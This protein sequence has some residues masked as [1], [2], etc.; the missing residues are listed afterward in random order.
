MRTRGRLLRMMVVVVLAGAPGYVGGSEP[1][2][3]NSAGARGER[4]ARGVDVESAG[5]GAV[6]RRY[7]FL[8]GV[9]DYGW[10]DRAGDG[11]RLDNLSFCV[12]DMESLKKKLDAIGFVRVYCMTTESTLSW[13]PTKDRIQRRF[14]QLLDDDKMDADDL[15]LVALAGHGLARPAADGNTASYFCPADAHSERTETMIAVDWFY[16]RLA[17][18]KAG[19]KLLVVDACRNLVKPRAAGDAPKLSPEARG[20]MKSLADSM[21]PRGIAALLSCSSGEFSHEVPDLGHGVFM[22]FV[23]EGL[24]KADRAAGNRDG[25]V[26][27]SGPVHVTAAQTQQYVDTACPGTYSKPRPLLRR[28]LPNYKLVRVARPPG[29][30]MPREL[31]LPFTVREKDRNGKLLEGATVQLL[32]RQSSGAPEAA[33]GRAQSDSRGRAEI[34]IP[35]HW[36]LVQGDFGVVVADRGASRRYALTDF[37]GPRSWSLYVPKDEPSSPSPVVPGQEPK[38]I[39]NSSGMKLPWIPAGA[40]LMGSPQ[41]EEHREDNEYQHRVRITK[42]FYLGADEVTQAEYERVMGKNPSWFSANGDGSEQ[43]QGMDTSRFPVEQVSWAEA[44]EFCRK[45]SSLPEGQRAGRVYRLPTEAEWEY[46]CRAGTRS[47]F[48]FGDSL[49]S[50]QANFDGDSPY[51][52]ASEGPDLGRPRPVGSYKPNGWGLYDMHGNVY[53]WCRDWYDAEYY[54]NSPV[55]DPV[56]PSSEAFSRVCRGGC[57]SFDAGYCRSSNRDGVSPSYRDNPLGFRVAAGPSGR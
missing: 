38:T 53:E 34:T 55:D 3:G 6:S 28:D 37:P 16:K 25:E 18:S 35:G 8:V 48:H 24:S 10:Y 27:L 33:I 9:N 47:V 57:W 45:L 46:A 15:V 19:M 41:G 42:P 22:H 49:S 54:K 20:F 5:V 50:T 12:A 30:A 1:P 13:Q 36:S 32:Y 11:D 7:A 39:T 4:P 2:G 51:G 23:L 40:V 44:V 56:G 26:S 43:V 52:G 17:K 31:K 21:P 29:P 14:E